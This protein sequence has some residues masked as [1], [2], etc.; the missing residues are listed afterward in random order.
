[1]PV[2]KLKTCT[3]RLG[4]ARVT[5]WEELGENVSEVGMLLV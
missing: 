2:R 5:N 1:L 3:A 4:R